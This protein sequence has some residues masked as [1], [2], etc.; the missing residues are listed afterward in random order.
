MSDVPAGKGLLMSCYWEKETGRG[1]VYRMRIK[2]C[3][4]HSCTIDRKL[5]QFV[6][7]NK[8]VSSY[9]FFTRTHLLRI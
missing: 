7:K 9:E 1:S 6:V 3:D 8:F 2:T 5:H 4:P